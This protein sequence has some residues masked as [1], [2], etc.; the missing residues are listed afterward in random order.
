MKLT[1]IIF[2]LLVFFPFYAKGK[3]IELAASDIEKMMGTYSKLED[4]GKYR[5]VRTGLCFQGEILCKAAFEKVTE[6][7]E[8]E[9]PKAEKNPETGKEEGEPEA[10]S[11]EKSKSGR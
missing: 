4:V 2:V 5:V 8:P 3:E 9:A 7:V 10:A 11:E 1:N 6:T